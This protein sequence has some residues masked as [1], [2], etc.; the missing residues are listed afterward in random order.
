MVLPVGIECDKCNEH[1]GQLEKTFLHHNHIWPT[2][3]LL[4][5]PGKRGRPRDRLGFM[6][7]TS[8]GF[9][10]RAP[11][12]RAKTTIR[13][14]KVETEG[15]NPA[16]FDDGKFRRALHHIAFNYVVKERG[17]EHGLRPEYDE[18][19]RYVRAAKPGERWPYAQVI[20]QRQ[21]T[22]SSLIE[23]KRLNLSF[24][25]AAPGLVVRF[26][27]YVDDFYVDVVN[28]GELHKWGARALPAD[29]GLL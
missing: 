11:A 25:P 24:V 16:E 1:A 13:P 4:E 14:G 20:V 9:M 15:G 29:V 17:H 10:M 23:S 12:R 22:R 19:R 3:M 8:D 18:V 6:E 26:E 7:R 28:S 27:C 2:L 21:H 5:V